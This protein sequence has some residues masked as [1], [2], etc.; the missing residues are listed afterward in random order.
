MLEQ[1]TE[2]Q[3]RGAATSI[4]AELVSAYHRHRI[5][6]R[7]EGPSK[8]P[9]R[10]CLPDA[11]DGAAF[12]VIRDYAL[13]LVFAFAGTINPSAGHRVG[14]EGYHAAVVRRIATTFQGNGALK[15]LTRLLIEGTAPNRAFPSVPYPGGRNQIYS[16]PTDAGLSPTNRILRKTMTRPAFDSSVSKQSTEM[17]NILCNHV[18]GNG[19]HERGE[20]PVESRLACRKP[21]GEQ[22]ARTAADDTSEN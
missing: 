14:S 4:A 17:R 11:R 1:M 22:H 13:V 16:Q 15:W 18:G 10:Y 5:P 19:E 8:A 3:S 21:C 9:H 12:E 20:N 6:G 7:H 2:I